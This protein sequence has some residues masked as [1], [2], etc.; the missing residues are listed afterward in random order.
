MGWDCFNGG[1]NCFGITMNIELNNITIEITQKKMKHLRLRVC[2]PMGCVKVSAPKRMS[3]ETIRKFVA[4]KLDWIQHQQNKIASRPYE[5]QKEFIDGESHFY[6]GEQYTLK[7]IEKNATPRVT[8]SDDHLIIQVRY[9]AD[10]EK[11]KS[12]LDSWY[13]QQLIEKINNLMPK[14]ES[15][16]NVSVSKFTIQKMKSRW[17]SCS[18]KSRSIRMSLALATKSPDCL[19]YVLV[20]ELTHLLEASHNKRFYLLMDQFLPNWRFCRDKLNNASKHH[21]KLPD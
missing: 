4:S 16:I 7:I 5:M 20:H 2:P 21:R 19:E 14:W 18:I 6:N 13:R 9:G 1:W 10:K 11:R 8:L 3:L 17:G 15:I 12:V